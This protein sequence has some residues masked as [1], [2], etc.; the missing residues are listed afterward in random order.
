MTESYET[1]QE[2]LR[3]IEEKQDEVEKLK[4]TV[5]S[6]EEHSI[7]ETNQS[8]RLMEESHYDWQHDSKLQQL[9][10]DQENVLSSIQ[11][12][13]MI[14]M[15]EWEDKIAKDQSKLCQKEETHRE[16]LHQLKLKELKEEQDGTIT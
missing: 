13:R 1:I 2:E 6:E 11:K 10:H 9:F 7:D 14:F 5:L 12:Q 3:Q 15:E 4:R 16:T 8:I